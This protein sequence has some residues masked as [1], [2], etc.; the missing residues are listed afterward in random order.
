[1]GS[2]LI[3]LNR[4]IVGFLLAA[5]IIISDSACLN[6]TLVD[7][8]ISKS[9][10]VFLSKN[11]Q[12]DYESVNKQVLGQQCIS[13]VCNRFNFLREFLVYG[14]RRVHRSQSHSEE[15]KMQNSFILWI[16]RQ[17]L[18]GQMQLNTHFFQKRSAS[19][20]ISKDVSNNRGIFSSQSER[21]ESKIRTILANQ[22]VS[23]LSSGIR[24]F[25]S[26]ILGSFHPNDLTSA[27]P[28]QAASEKYR[29]DYKSVV[30]S[31]FFYVNKYGLLL[32][33]IA[34]IGAW[35]FISC[36]RGIYFTAV[37][38]GLDVIATLGALLWAYWVSSHHD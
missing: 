26:C 29:E 30:P 4:I 38:A 21:R 14:Q 9:E 8:F 31:I 19:A 11:V 34:Y 25:L 35:F 28:N 2:V 16:W 1:M 22:R 23:I 3:W 33:V 5:S 12:I 32:V 27:N 24:R 10:R 36:D 20:V 6:K 18:S 13:Y 17:S 37:G 15:R 7:V